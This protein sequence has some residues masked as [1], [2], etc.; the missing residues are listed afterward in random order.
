MWCVLQ[1]T[2]QVYTA[3]APGA[4]AVFA[5][6]GQ[7]NG[8]DCVSC[9]GFA[10][11]RQSDV[12]PLCYSCRATVPTQSARLAVLNNDRAPLPPFETSTTE[13]QLLQ[14]MLSAKR[15]AH[16]AAV[17]GIIRELV[18]SATYPGV[19]AAPTIGVWVKHQRVERS[20]LW[21]LAYLDDA[22]PPH[23][24]LLLDAALSD[25]PAGLIRYNALPLACSRELLCAAAKRWRPWFRGTV[26]L[27]EQCASVSN[28]DGL[29]AAAAAWPDPM[30]AATAAALLHT[31]LD[32]SWVMQH[33]QSLVPQEDRDDALT[34]L[35]EMGGTAFAVGQM[36]CLGAPATPRALLAGVTREPT[37]VAV[38][39]ALL[40]GGA[41]ASDGICIAAERGKAGVVRL[42]LE[43][44][45]DPNHPEGGIRPLT[46]CVTSGRCNDATVATLLA[47][48]AH[49]SASMYAAVVAIQTIDS[50]ELLTALLAAM[51]NETPARQR[52]VTS[53]DLVWLSY[54]LA[55]VPAGRMRT[56]IE[57]VIYPFNVAPRKEWR[58]AVQRCVDAWSNTPGRANDVAML[59]CHFGTISGRSALEECAARSESGIALAL[60]TRHRLPVRSAVDLRAVHALFGGRD[61]AWRR[62]VVAAL[63]GTIGHVL[64][65]EL[66]E[67]IAGLLLCP[68]ESVWTAH[69]AASPCTAP[70]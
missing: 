50:D 12:V 8:N 65:A 66:I 13:G 25:A 22:I 61:A 2:G 47:A 23:A 28:L 10:T 56:M 33:P 57:H 18:P 67:K 20:I 40:A 44:D 37:D 24:M 49:S 6:T 16:T 55:G 7:S 5:L 45:A 31:N 53:A 43:H 35:I 42:L 21:C 1:T 17:V 46:R 9:G 29:Y 32:T 60:L 51:P 69:I 38:V 3:V 63:T 30:L 19:L 62:E 52:R 64:P 39:R 4:D 48:G 27:A 11:M 36:L 70:P 26:L 54:E 15:S 68:A 34:M 41:V 14:R 59:R 58:L